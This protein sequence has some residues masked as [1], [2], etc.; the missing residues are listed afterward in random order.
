MQYFP[1]RDPSFRWDDGFG[2]WD[3]DLDQQKLGSRPAIFPG[4]RFLLSME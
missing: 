4:L 2:R 3:D 1:A